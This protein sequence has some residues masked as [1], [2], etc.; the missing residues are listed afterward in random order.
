MF[1]KN[2]KDKLNRKVDEWLGIDESG[3][4][5]FLCPSAV[6]FSFFL[7]ESSKLLISNLYVKRSKRCVSGSNQ[8]FRGFFY[9]RES[10]IRSSWSVVMCCE[11][12]CFA[13]HFSSILY[14]CPY[15]FTIRF[16]IDPIYCSLSR[17]SSSFLLNLYFLS[18]ILGST[19]FR[20][21]FFSTYRLFLVSLS[22][23][24]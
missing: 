23:H 15:N 21:M 20:K 17:Y 5:P 9:P 18:T 8:P 3:S 19:I 16:C 4:S 11:Y 1:K 24:A 22:G 12:I 2:S 10:P 7:E 13:G 14:K 6:E